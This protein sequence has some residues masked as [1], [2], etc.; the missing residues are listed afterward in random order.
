MDLTL[1][2]AITL[3]VLHVQ[4]VKTEDAIALVKKDHGYS[5]SCYLQKR[6]YPREQLFNSSSR[7]CRVRQVLLVKLARKVIKVIPVMQVNPVKK[8]IGAM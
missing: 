4:I 6:K 8:V 7:V 5:L 2:Q 1:Y 3:T